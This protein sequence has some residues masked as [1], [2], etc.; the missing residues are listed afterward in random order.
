MAT[1]AEYLG[2]FFWT[3]VKFAISPSTMAATGRYDFWQIWLT[4][5]IS[6][7]IGVTV[8]YYFGNLIFAWVDS[9]RSRKR[10]IFSKG[11]RRMVR[12]LRRYGL[13]G[14]ALVSVFLSVPIAGLVAAKFFHHQRGI[15][16]LLYV[17]FTTWSLILTLLSVLAADSI[18]G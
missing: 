9:K 17:S 15:L 18:H 12:I 11:S 6:A 4:T 8:F 13:P 10:R 14:L 2:W 16:G 5:S 3:V 1:I 7:M